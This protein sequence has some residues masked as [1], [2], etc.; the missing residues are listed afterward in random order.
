MMQ[1]DRERP[2]WSIARKFCYNYEPHFG[3]RGMSGNGLR[4]V[5]FAVLHNGRRVLPP[6]TLRTLHGDLLDQG[7]I[8]GSYCSLCG[9]Q[10]HLLAMLK[11]RWSRPYRSIRFQVKVFPPI[12]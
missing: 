12:T 5:P 7:E 6:N 3:F 8:S 4:S 1:V 2:F 11:I 10:A 9:S